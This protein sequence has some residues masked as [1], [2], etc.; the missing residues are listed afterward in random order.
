MFKELI[1][2]IKK[3]PVKEG[4]YWEYYEGWTEAID[5]ILKII[6]SY[7]PEVLD[8][9]NAEGGWWNTKSKEYVQVYESNDGFDYPV[10]CI[11]G[12]W[13]KTDPPETE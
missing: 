9:P 2:K 11:G 8:E 1:E 10:R 6:E 7:K 12:K 5:E 3:M 13:I 4:E